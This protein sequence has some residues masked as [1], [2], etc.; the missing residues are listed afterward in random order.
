MYRTGF[1]IC[2]SLLT[3][4][5][6]SSGEK[7]GEETKTEVRFLISANGIIDLA[8]YEGRLP[9]IVFGEQKGSEAKITEIA[10]SDRLN[11]GEDYGFKPGTYQEY[12]FP[13]NLGKEE[14]GEVG[15]LMEKPAPLQGTFRLTNI[16]SIGNLDLTGSAKEVEMTGASHRAFS[17]TIEPFKGK[18]E[19]TA[20]PGAE[21]QKG[22][23]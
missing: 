18:V 15:I 3:V 8:V 2:L 5:G 4:T 23:K 16:K 20:T 13:V 17:A 11:P 7:K 10:N 21:P 19:N 6:C 14:F 12:F 22:D 9:A 1:A